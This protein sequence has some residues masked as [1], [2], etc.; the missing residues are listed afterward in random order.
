MSIETSLYAALSAVCP[1]VFPD[2]APVETTRPY[3]VWQMVGGPSPVYT[4]NTQPN[5]AAAFVQITVWDD[6]R[7]VANT[8]TRQIEAALMAATTMQARPLSALTA[9]FDDGNELRG[10]MQDFEIWAPR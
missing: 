6:S 1:R 3:V 4:E 9:A 2:V 8:L 7:L 10:S 5:Q